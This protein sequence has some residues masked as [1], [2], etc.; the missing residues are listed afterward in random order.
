MDQGLGSDNIIRTIVPK[1]VN[2]Q[3]HANY[4]AEFVDSFENIL[5][6]LGGNELI[7]QVRTEVEFDIGRGAD[8]VEALTKPYERIRGDIQ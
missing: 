6:A 8:I 7:D 4:V 3:Q 5:Y 2:L 1:G